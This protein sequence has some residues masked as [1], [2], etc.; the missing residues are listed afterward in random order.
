[1]VILGGGIT[2]LAIAWALS[3][4]REVTVVD[5]PRTRPSSTEA[6]AAM[7]APGA[8]GCTA[9]AS[10]Y[11][12]GKES[13]LLYPGFLD[14]V[15]EVSG[16]RVELTSRGTLL[17]AEDREGERWLQSR[18]RELTHLS[19]PYER[20]LGSEVRCLEPG[21]LDTIRTALL[22]PGDRTLSIRSL[23]N[24]LQQALEKRGVVFIERE[25]AELRWNGRWQLDGGAASEEVVV[26][27]GAWLGQIA[28]PTTLDCPKLFPNQGVLVEL[29]VEQSG[30]LHHMVR[31]RR[32]Y[33]CPKE[34]G[35]LL[36]GA[37]TDYVG[38]DLRP[39]LGGIREILLRAWELL[40]GIDAAYF[41]K[42]RVGLRPDGSGEVPTLGK[43]NMAGLYWAVGHGRS[44]VLLAPWSARQ[45]ERIAR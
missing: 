31:S 21:L 24:A 5:A 14:E 34:D 9:T 44:G 43:S 18:E 6:S 17:V 12:I 3:K 39:A 28:V 23:Q 2:G 11:Q 42:V 22:I 26:A 36:A 35:T 32:I 27:P 8:E 7:I 37:T 29:A 41:S 19:E 40:P 20:L 38:C 16:S 30:R 33:L 25:V 13:S 10:L 1:M 15:S 4:S 45:M